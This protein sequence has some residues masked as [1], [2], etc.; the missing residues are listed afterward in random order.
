MVVSDRIELSTHGFSV[1]CSTDW[2]MKPIWRSWRESNPR[3]PLWQRGMLITTPQ[4]Q[5][6]REWDSNPRPPDYE[7]DELPTALSRDKIYFKMADD[8]GFEPP[9]TF[10]HLSVFKTDPFNQAW[11]IIHKNYCNIKISYNKYILYVNTRLNKLVELTGLEPVT[12]R[13]WVGG[14]NQLSYSSNI[15]WQEW[16]LNPRHPGYEPSSLT[17]WD[18]LP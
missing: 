4:N 15:W 8:E 10:Q 3:S 2:A 14:S 5:W 6:L 18:T 7:P 1:R 9:R 13:L 16:D 17:N 11:V 12:Y